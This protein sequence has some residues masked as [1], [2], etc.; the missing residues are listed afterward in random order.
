MNSRY[1]QVALASACVMIV[2]A[3]AVSD[4]VAGAS[5]EVGP[6]AT[7]MRNVNLHIGQGVELLIDDL[8]GR[9]LNRVSG[10]PPAFDDLDSYVLNI[11]A[12]RVSMTAAS[13]TNLMNN[14][15]FAYPGAPLTR[16]KLTI[17]NG[18]L[19]Q[20]G[21]LRK[22]IGIPFTMHASVAATKEGKIRLHPTA[23]KAAGAIPKRLLDF[24]GL[25]LD[26]LITLA[27]G[28][29]ITIDG[30]DLL[31]D[32]ERLLPP[33]RIHGHLTN[34]AIDKGR[35]IEYFGDVEAA[36]HGVA[37]PNRTG[38]NYMYFRG[39]TLRFGKLTMEDTDL[40]LVDANPKGPFEFSPQKYN[41]QLVAGY[42]KNT[43][44]HGLIVYMPSLNDLPRAATSG[45]LTPAPTGR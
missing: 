31:L 7:R 2:S 23:M 3:I 10:K 1:H 42:S 21:T 11:D 40:L 15:V 25:T 30:D 9:M 22:G 36:R 12:A 33:P 43:P 14:Y 13:L 39:G 41:D 5:P 45:G 4:R 27:P 8:N 28:S 38:S 35:L 20:S 17:E 37:P 18:E 32:P 34:V 24:F 6:V 44:T 16:L 19:T 26:R 29:P